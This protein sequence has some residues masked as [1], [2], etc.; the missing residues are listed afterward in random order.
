M[1]SE[2]RTV[3]DSNTRITIS[4]PVSAMNA[5]RH[6]SLLSFMILVRQEVLNAPIPVQSH[7]VKG[8]KIYNFK[9]NSE[10]NTTGSVTFRRKQKQ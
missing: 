1:K 9:I 5:V 2:G 8:P 4:N 3:L 7:P 10:L 6:Y